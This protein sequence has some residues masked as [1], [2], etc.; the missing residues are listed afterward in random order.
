ML[1]DEVLTSMNPSTSAE[2]KQPAE[3]PECDCLHVDRCP[4][5]FD[6]P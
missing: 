2:P 3:E 5:H 6:Y 4:V 1:A